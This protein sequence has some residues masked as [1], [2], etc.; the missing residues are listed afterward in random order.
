MTLS[1]VREV[2]F[3]TLLFL[4]VYLCMQIRTYWR[5]ITV[6][7]YI[8][9]I[10]FKLIAAQYTRF[11]DIATVHAHVMPTYGVPSFRREALIRAAYRLVG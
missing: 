10:C 5:Y 6:F 8:H 3:I 9:E 2:K 11:S 1:Q 7:I 4:T